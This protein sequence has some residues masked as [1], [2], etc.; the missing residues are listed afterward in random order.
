[1]ENIKSQFR[2]VIKSET[3]PEMLKNIPWE[4]TY[5]LL[6]FPS[7]M[8]MAMP[9]WQLF[10]DMLVP[11][12]QVNS[13]H[14]NISTINNIALWTGIISVI[15]MISKNAV[16]H[17]KKTVIFS[18]K[19]PFIFFGIVILF[20]L[21]S[22]AV[23]G[24]TDY[25]IHGDSYRGESLLVTVMYFVFYFTSSAAVNTKKRKAILIYAYMISSIA[26]AVCA[27]ITSCIH[28]LEGIKM[29]TGLSAIFHHFNHY[30]YFL[31]MN[32]MTSE[33]LFI[34]EKNKG[35]KIL[36]LVS[37]V[38]NI[39][40]L[41]INDTFGCYLACFTAL[42]FSVIVL[43]IC[44]KKFNKISV[45]MTVIFIL[46]SLVMSIWYDTIFSNLF[47]FSK[48]VATITSSSS[49]EAAAKS[50]GTGRW[51]LWVYTVE[52]IKEKPLFGW[53]LE[54]TTKQLGELVGHTDRPHNEYLQYAAFFGIPASIAYICGVFSV[55]LNGLKHKYELDIYTIAALVAS[56]GY[57][58]SAAFGN[59]MYYTSPAFFILLGLAFNTRK[60]GEISA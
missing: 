49:T 3:V 38:I 13:I 34:K 20:M 40:V 57:L 21:I 5:V 59:T 51:E 50:A 6:F 23:N 45:L 58:V 44:D 31:L 25:V 14:S 7:L 36:S 55:F 22:T 10:E 47:T 43:S 17:P 27:L 37:F 9:L 8:M 48:D 46:I 15:I 26:I 18:T 33:V 28:P 60:C 53:G 24:I 52:F 29:G 16:E 30:G 1:M 4:F 11:I 42:I 39:V 35:L 2:K 56:F 12:G 54:G 32:I 41:I 19:T